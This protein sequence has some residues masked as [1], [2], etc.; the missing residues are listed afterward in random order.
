METKKNP[1][2]GVKT[3][4]CEKNLPKFERKKGIQMEMMLWELANPNNQRNTRSREWWV[5]G[6]G[7]E[8]RKKEKW[9]ESIM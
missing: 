8:E 1:P 6:N 5:R 9:P 3:R 4:V 2:N 7:E